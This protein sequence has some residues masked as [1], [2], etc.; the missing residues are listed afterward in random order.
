M[1][2]WDD[3]PQRAGA[4]AAGGGGDAGAGAGAADAGGTFGFARRWDFRRCR[5]GGSAACNSPTTGLG[6][7]VVVGGDAKSP[8][9]WVT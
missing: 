6:S 5:F 2:R 8:G 3:P 1:I 9:T 7:K 4:G